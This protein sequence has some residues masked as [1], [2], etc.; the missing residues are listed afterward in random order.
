MT[1]LA[2]FP[3]ITLLSW[4]TGGVYEET[5]NVNIKTA[6][7]MQKSWKFIVGKSSLLRITEEMA[8]FSY[9]PGDFML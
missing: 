3:P 9:Y 4:H 1:W 7:T 2:Y 8:K 5:L 6:Q